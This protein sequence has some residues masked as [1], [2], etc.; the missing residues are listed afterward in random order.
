MI[1]NVIYLQETKLSVTSAA[2]EKQT[3]ISTSCPQCGSAVTKY[4]I[5]AWFYK[6]GFSG[7]WDTI[8]RVSNNPT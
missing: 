5:S 3:Q 6:R 8:F 1:E 7:G 4:G 2:S